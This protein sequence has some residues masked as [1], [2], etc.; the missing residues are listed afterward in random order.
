M[1]EKI[2]R[3]LKPE[4][5]GKPESVEDL[6]LLGREIVETTEMVKENSAKAEQQAEAVIRQGEAVSAQVE[7]QSPKQQAARETLKQNHSKI[8]KLISEFREASYMFMKLVVFSG[9]VLAGPN[10]GVAGLETPDQSIQRARQELKVK[11][12][13]SEQRRAYKFV[14][15]DALEK[16]IEPLGYKDF[17]DTVTLGLSNLF[18]KRRELSTMFSGREDAWRLYLGL[19]QTNNTFGIS[20]Y[21]PPGNLR[22]HK[23]TPY[24]FKINSYWENIFKKNGRDIIGVKIEVEGM[25]PREIIK[26]I[27]NIRRGLMTADFT[28]HIMGNYWITSGVDAGGHFIQY[29]DRW[30]LDKNKIEGEKGFFGKPFEIYDRLYYDP[31]T[32]E[33]IGLED[34][35]VKKV[36][37][38]L[39]NESQQNLGPGYLPQ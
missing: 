28:T 32:Y 26:Q 7:S 11:G 25:S 8:Q 29:Y 21:T 39:A 13:T 18:G 24:Y 9:A 10:P 30:D 31:K 15:N 33:P 27:V 37:H 35:A 36:I 5:L 12:I 16:A 1:K 19:P 14:V 34:S 2:E 6:A 17:S 22:P 3:N 4:V 23:D 20:E 38:S